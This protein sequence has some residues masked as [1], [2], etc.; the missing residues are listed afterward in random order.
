V[1][2]RVYGLALGYEDVND[3]EQLRHDPL[4]ALLAGRKELERP[5]AGKS[6]LYRLEMGADEAGR[7]RKIGYHE[8]D[9][10]RLLVDLLL[11]A[12]AQPPRRIVLDLDATDMLLHGH[13]ENRFFHG[14]YDSYCYLPLYI[15]AGDQLLCARLRAADRDAASGAVDERQRIIAQIRTRWPKVEI[16]VRADSAFCR[17]ELMGWCERTRWSTCWGWRATSGCGAALA[18]PRP[19]PGARP[20]AAAARRGSLP[21]STIARSGVG[22]ARAA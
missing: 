10:D 22:P 11:E 7:Y 1:A 3:H 20:S 8:D 21:S 5:L 6:T 17:E 12:H 19:A 16:V 14:F 2:Q 15:F 4:L 9:S 13:Q 18:G